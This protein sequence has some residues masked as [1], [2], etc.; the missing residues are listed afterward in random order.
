MDIS[1][2]VKNIFCGNPQTKMTSVSFRTAASFSR[3]W[4]FLLSSLFG[5]SS[6]S[7][8]KLPIGCFLLNR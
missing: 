4:S 2:F 7:S 6:L 3:E 1:L 5:F 8:P